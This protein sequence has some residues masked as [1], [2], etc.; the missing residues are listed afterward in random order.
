M[1]GILSSTATT[2]SAAVQCIRSLRPGR[3]CTA[4][5]GFV[6]PVRELSPPPLMQCWFCTGKGGRQWAAWMLN[7]L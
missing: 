3:P 6:A 4:R 2:G 5:K 7:G 1:V